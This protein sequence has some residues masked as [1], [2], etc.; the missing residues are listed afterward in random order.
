VADA[1]YHVTARGLERREIFT[2]LGKKENLRERQGHTAPSRGGSLTL[3][4]AGQRIGLP[5]FNAAAQAIRRLFARLLRDQHLRRFLSKVI[6]CI[7]V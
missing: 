4:A 3:R 7:K 5:H 2:G 1:W 6:K